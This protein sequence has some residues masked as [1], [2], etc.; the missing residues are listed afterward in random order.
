V[1]GNYDLAEHVSGLYCSFAQQ[2]FM[3]LEI[4]MWFGVFVLSLFTLLK[5]ADYFIDYAE[6]IGLS[7]GISQLVIGVTV[8]ALGTSLPEL[9]SSIAAIFKDT[10]EIVFSNVMGSNIT[11][12]LLVFGAMCLLGSGKTIEE[13]VPIHNTIFLLVGTGFLSFAIY[14]GNFELWEGVVCVVLLTAYLGMCVKATLRENNDSEKPKLKWYYFLIVVLA[15]AGIYLSAEFNI[16]SIIQIADLANIGADIISAS[17]VAL[18]TSLP[19]LIV[20]VSAVKKG[21]VSLAIGNVIGSN[22]F[23]ALGVSGVSRFFGELEIT[24]I[25]LTVLL[26]LMAL[27]TILLVIYYNSKKLQNWKGF[28]LLALYVAFLVQVVIHSL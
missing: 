7:L 22:I 4:L 9:A 6:R 23:N 12:V 10:S 27:A 26:P 14:D 1:L 21:K 20:S 24:H 13:R 17:A 18:G 16:K 19:E 8:V 15:G 5:S 2:Q 3:A 11:N 28:I 25:N